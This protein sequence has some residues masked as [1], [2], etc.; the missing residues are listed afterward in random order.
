[1]SEDVSRDVDHAASALSEIV[2]K[3]EKPKG[4]YFCD[5]GAT[6]RTRR[7]GTTAPGY[8]E[9]NAG[10]R[11][12]ALRRARK[13]IP[14]EEKR[15]SGGKQGTSGLVWTCHFEAGSERAVYSATSALWVRR[16]P[17]PGHT[18]F[19]NPRLFSAARKDLQCVEE[20]AVRQSLCE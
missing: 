19:T 20:R 16:S 2:A 11:H 15:N 1:M 18:K 6:W 5:E 17:G 8:S 12:P 3:K 13:R 4:V 10:Y 9:E 7:G 14:V